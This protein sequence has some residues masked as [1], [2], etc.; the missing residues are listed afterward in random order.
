MLSV[1]CSF[2]VIFFGARNNF[3]AFVTLFRSKGDKDI[4]S[5][6]IHR[7]CVE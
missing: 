4:R 2:P 7:S 3:I 5:S 1:L 6:R